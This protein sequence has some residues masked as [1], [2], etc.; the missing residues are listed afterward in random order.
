MRE[1]SPLDNRERLCC[2]SDRIQVSKDEINAK[3]N[4]PKPKST[5]SW[6]SHIVKGLTNDR[7]YKQKPPV[8]S[9]KIP[10]A[11]SVTSN[12]KVQHACYHSRVKRS[13]IGDF[14]CSANAAQVHHHV[15]SPV[16]R[17]LYAELDHL[18]HLLQESKA[19]EL[20][21]QAELEEYKSNSEVMCL[22]KVLESK[23]RQ[24]EDLS[25]R[26]S[27][28]ENERW[29]LLEQLHEDS[30][31]KNL[32]MQVV[33]LRRV[34]MELQHQKR[35]LAF[36]LSIAES[37]LAGLKRASEGDIVSKL[38]AETSIL[39]H[40]NEDLC[41]QV[42][43]PM[44][45]LNEV[46]ELA[47]LRWI[48]SCFHRELD[49]SN[50]RTRMSI[51][52]SR[53]EILTSKGHD[54]AEDAKCELSN[55]GNSFF[56]DSRSVPSEFSEER[57]VTIVK[58][59]RIYP[60]DKEFRADPEDK[61]VIRRHSISGVKNCVEDLKVNLR[62]QSDPRHQ[63]IAQK[64]ELGSVQSPCALVN[65]VETY[66]AAAMDV[67]K[68][69]L[70]ILNP[71]PK[72]SI[73]VTSVH[74]KIMQLLAPQLIELY[75]SLMR[76][77]P[78]NDPGIG[79]ICDDV[80]RKGNFVKSLIKEVNGA[81]YHDIEDVIKFVKWLDDELTVLVDEGAVLKYF[82]WPE[83]KAD[84]L[85]EAAFEYHDLKK[86]ESEIRQY[87]DDPHLPSAVAL[88]KM[89]VLSEK[90]ERKVHNLVRAR[91]G[92]IRHY[93]QFEIPTD[94]ILDTGIISKIKISSMKLA[95]K[96]MRRIFMEL[97]AAA[98]SYK[99]PAMEYMLLQGVRFALRIHQFAGGFDGETM[100]A[101]DELRNLVHVRYKT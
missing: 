90:M 85:R 2:L 98:V 81:I 22:K 41:K 33:E 88:K 87:E 35:N 7:K 30:T 76:K 16:S 73:S 10:L 83:K 96:Y 60:R 75:H 24:V 23:R 34:N 55:C 13:L 97:Q 31:R 93:K 101:L 44:T 3:G 49:N 27:S 63:L 40:T 74:K 6:G 25:R 68:D 84:T 17:D 66:K 71:P 79:G 1:D 26:I 65:Q 62:R 15:N 53:E 59:N 54:A 14:P 95:N 51:S 86:L 21:L 57:N 77:E 99:D 46:E 11:C 72:P 70:H 92:L 100:Q 61:S 20:E 52:S 91:D 58:D 42:G 12:Q 18:R 4:R 82:D 45:R 38:E 64:Y 32:E 8:T 78:R 43:V 28:F 47:Y 67:E 36:E 69:T 9:K 80:E 19:R 89:V 48:N 94:W 37:Q 39:H 56:F 29:S 5:S 50:N